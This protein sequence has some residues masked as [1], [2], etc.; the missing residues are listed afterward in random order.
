MKTTTALKITESDHKSIKTHIDSAP[1][2]EVCG[3][4]GGVWKPYAKIAV[5][6]M[7]VPVKNIDSH[8]ALRFTMEPQELYNA[9][10]DF[11]KQGCEVIGIYHSHPYG[12]TQPSA[13]DITEA[14]YSDA[15]YLIGVPGGNLSAW[16]ILRGEIRPVDIEIITHVTEL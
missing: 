9:L 14:L 3:L 16:R 2:V 15:V 7:V 10:L 8:P 6:R 12:T 4:I 13:S 11:E 5:A 1:E